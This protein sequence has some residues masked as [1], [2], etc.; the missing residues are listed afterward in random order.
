L[1]EKR[2][3]RHSRRD[4]AAQ[5]HLRRV[6]NEKRAEHGRLGRAFWQAMVDCVDQHRGAERVGQENEFLTRIAAFLADG[7]EERDGVSPFFKRRLD[8]AD[9]LVQMT[10]ER[11]GHLANPRRSGV[12]DP[13]EDRGGDC[14][15]VEI[16]H[17]RRSG[18]AGRI[19]RAE[20]GHQNSGAGTRSP[21]L[22]ASTPKAPR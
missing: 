11:L 6:L 7:G 18:R 12:L 9:E 10:Y 22:V 5:R 1:N 2:L 4:V 20:G 13:L 16:A 15:L 8:L 3:P 21:I 17:R 19:F 14:V